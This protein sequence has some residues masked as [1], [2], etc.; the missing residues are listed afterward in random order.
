M[1]ALVPAS[2]HLLRRDNICNWKRGVGMGAILVFQEREMSMQLIRPT[3]K[4]AESWRAAMAEFR[5][6]G[7]KGFWNWENEPERLADY[8]RKTEDNAAGRDLTE[9]WVPSSTFWRKLEATLA[10]TFGPQP[11]HRDMALKFLSWHWERLA[12]WD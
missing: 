6:E 5:S 12:S 7:M 11:G 2:L 8:I 1:V 4:Y 3:L 10:I 9:G